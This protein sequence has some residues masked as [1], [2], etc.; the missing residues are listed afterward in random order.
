MKE[1]KLN[2]DI[3]SSTYKYFSTRPSNLYSEIGIYQESLLNNYIDI[4]NPNYNNVS[5]FVEAMSGQS[6]VYEL[7]TPI[8]IQLTPTVVKSLRGVNNISADSGDVRDGK[9]IADA[10]LTIASLD[11]RITAL[12]NQ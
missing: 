7:A 4:Y 11:A 12:E 8:T 9:Y 10:S 6:L 3:I 1:K 2:T 5:D